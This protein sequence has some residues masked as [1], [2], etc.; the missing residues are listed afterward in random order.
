MLLAKLPG[1][2]LLLMQKEG[3]PKPMIQENMGGPK[4]KGS[5]IH[6]ISYDILNINQ[7][8]KR[9]S[10]E[11]FPIHFLKSKTLIFIKVVTKEEGPNGCC[12]AEVLFCS[13]QLKTQQFSCLTASQLPF[14][15]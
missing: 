3:C 14:G 12:V 6:G 8:L 1:P 9:R 5:V 2:H 11:K 4:A 13:R 10:E 15:S 7:I